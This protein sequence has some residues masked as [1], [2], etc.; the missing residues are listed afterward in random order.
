MHTD[1]KLFKRVGSVA[2]AIALFGMALMPSTAFAATSLE[3]GEN[4]AITEAAEGTGSNGGTWSWDGADALVLDNYDGGKIKAYGGDLNIELNGKNTVDYA[5]P[6]AS[7]LDGCAIIV[8]EGNLTVTDR[9]GDGGTL[10]ATSYNGLVA[11]NDPGQDNGNV[12]IE[13]T[14][15]NITGTYDDGKSEPRRTAGIKGDGHVSIKDSSVTIEGVGYG[16]IGCGDVSISNSTVNT[17]SDLSGITAFHLGGATITIDNS[18]ISV[19]AGYHAMLAYDNNVPPKN[20]ITPGV[21]NIENATILTPNVQVVDAAKENRY[22]IY[23]IGQTLGTG[24]GP[25]VVNRDGN[26]VKDPALAKDVQISKNP[27]PAPAPT[28][29]PAEDTTAAAANIPQTGDDLPLALIT[30]CIITA[31][32]AIWLAHRR[33]A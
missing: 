28:P 26:W 21:I 8:N 3:I 14:T 6:P 20:P 1:N 23:V 29:T 32:A 17:T 25:I 19:H 24:N 7:D 13:N 18:D 2:T 15:V 27:S 16:V 31:G 4:P 10:D 12:T 22:G 30:V 33:I 9:D 11:H 5:N